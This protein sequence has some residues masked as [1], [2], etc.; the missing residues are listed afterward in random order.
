MTHYDKMS[1]IFMAFDKDKTG[2]LEKSELIN[3]IQRCNRS[4]E[5]TSLQL[6][7]IV[8]QVSVDIAKGTSKSSLCSQKGNTTP[9]RYYWSM[10]I[11]LMHQA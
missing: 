6:D 9:A 11:T 3:L 7:A 10:N 1:A 8:S 4:V 5:L 2:L